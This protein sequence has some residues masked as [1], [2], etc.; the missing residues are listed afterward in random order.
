MTSHAK[1]GIK[2][3][4]VQ[5]QIEVLHAGFPLSAKLPPNSNN[6]AVKQYHP[7][8]EKI[9]GS[10]SRF[11]LLL[12]SDDSSRNPLF[13]N[14]CVYVPQ[15]DELYA[16]SGLLQST[17]SS[18]LPTILISQVS[19]QREP[20]NPLQPI[21]AVGWMKLRPPQSM[22]MPAGACLF[23]DGILYCSQGTLASD[24]GG[25]W[26]M[27]WRKAPAPLLVGYFRKPFNSIQNVVQDREGG[28]WF[29]DA[30]A[31][32]ELDIRPKPKL[33]N[34]VYRVDGNGG[35]VR[36][37]ADGFGRPT[38][39]TLSPDESTLY[40][41]DTDANRPD[42]STDPTRAATIYAFDIIQRSGSYFLINR[43]L[44]AY[45]IDGVPMAVACDDSGNVYAACGDGVEVWSPGGVVLGLIEVPGGCTSLCFGR[46]GELFIG[47]GQRLWVFR[48][49]QQEST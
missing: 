35:N 44:F 22:P 46:K 1:T 17:N 41:T 29:T 3:S 25:L 49:T 38:G 40:V 37:V 11:S 9:T 45:A 2:S 27:A 5:T 14:G 23:K 42:G 18:A 43:R 13:R 36:V 30:S 20:D 39:I 26:Y 8:F 15:R 6:I 34:Q 21:C 28:L 7:D 16:M 33:P 19:L 47:A 32:F 24:T 31:G 10:E 4:T 12:S 48:L